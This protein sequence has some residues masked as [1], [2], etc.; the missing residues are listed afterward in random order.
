MIFP[1]QNA[2]WQQLWQAKLHHRLPHALLLTGLAG[3][4]KTKFAEV[5]SY[6]LL[7]SSVSASGDACHT[8]HACRLIATRV[9]PNVLWIEAEKSGAAIKVD[10]VRA[11]NE[12]ISHSSLQGEIR[13]VII[14]SAHDLNINAANALLK[15]L[16]EPAAGALI[17]LISDHFSRLPATILSR[18]QRI[19]FPKPPTALA[20]KW[21]LEQIKSSDIDAD[22]FLNLTHGAPLMALKFIQ[23]DGLSARQN[24]FEILFLLSK[25]KADPL[26]STLKIQSLELIPLLDFTLSFMLDLLR[27]QLSAKVP[28]I[29]NHDYAQQLHELKQSTQLKNNMQ[30]ME[31]LQQVRQQILSGINLNKQLVIEDLFIHWRKY[32]N[33]FG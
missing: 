7:C 11:I 14:P 15:T 22:F 27:L 16:E 9:H 5:F 25:N 6:A 24:I 21:L 32:S 23:E 31:Y 29:I 13:I 2:Q 18:C 10:Q 26:Q 17:M 4:G 33:V 20:K 1:W 8:C 3:T 12:F 19:L 28:E 30:F